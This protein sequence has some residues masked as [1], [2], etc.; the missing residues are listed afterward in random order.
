[1]QRPGRGKSSVY[2]CGTSVYLRHKKGRRAHNWHSAVR[3]TPKSGV[4]RFGV[5]P[6]VGGHKSNHR[7]ENAARIEPSGR[8]AVT[9]FW[10]AGA[11]RHP[12]P[13]GMAGKTD[14]DGRV[15]RGCIRHLLDL[16][17]VDQHDQHRAAG[18]RAV[19]PA[20]AG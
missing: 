6:A 11:E 2:A 8:G 12:G 16:V 7:C 13:S 1:M 20:D 10:T 4:V 14:S 18:D 19:A 5:R 15:D 9:A 17:A 3:E